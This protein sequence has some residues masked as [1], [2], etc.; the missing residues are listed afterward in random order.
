MFSFE[1]CEISKNTFFIE[2]LWW[3]LQNH[4]MNNFLIEDK[5]IADIGSEEKI[6]TSVQKSLFRWK[7]EDNQL[8][9]WNFGGKH[10]AFPGLFQ[11]HK[12]N[13]LTTNIVHTC[14]FQENYKNLYFW[15]KAKNKCFRD[16]YIPFPANF[17]QI[18]VLPSP[19]IGLIN[20]NLT[21]NKVYTYFNVGDAKILISLKA[22]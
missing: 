13:V 15:E 12:K 8:G 6:F 11:S 5:G 19:V 18:F 7:N 4:S 14:V 10:W 21:Q 2:R 22:E 17:G 3:L 20:E 1:F 16:K 9:T